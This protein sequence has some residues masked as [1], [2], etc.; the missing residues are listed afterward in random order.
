MIAHPRPAVGTWARQRMASLIPALAFTLG[1]G[2]VALL[3]V[4]KPRLSADAMDGL[5]RQVMGR[6]PVLAEMGGAHGNVEYNP[7]DPSVAHRPLALTLA[8]A[9][10]YFVAVL[11]LGAPIVAAV[12]GDDRWP[13]A[14][15]GLA[16]FL[17]GYL[18]VL[19]PVQLLYGVLPVRTASWVALAAVPAAAILLH[20][21]AITAA[22]VEPGQRAAHARRLGWAAVG[23]VLMVLVM[24]VHRLQVD[25]DY[26]TQD[27]IHWFLEAG[28]QQLGQLLGTHLAQWASQSDEWVFNA[29]LMFSSTNPGDIWLPFYLTQAIGIASVAALAYGLVHRHAR[30]RK[31]L[32]GVVVVSAMFTATVSIYPWVYV[33]LVIGGQPL[34]WL[35]HTGRL[36]GI[37]APWAALLLV[38]R[39]SRSVTALLALTTMGLAFT[40]AEVLPHV[41]IA[42][43][44]VL[45][46]RA[47]S[48]RRAGWLEGRGGALVHLL[49]VAALSLCALPFWAIQSFSDKDQAAWFL[50]AAMLLALAGA[51][52]L[53]VNSAPVVTQPS[54]S[55]RWLVV[56]PLVAL[57]G[58]LLSNNLIGGSE[59]GEAIR[60][61]IGSVLPGFRGELLQRPDIG[62]GMFAGLSFPNLSEGACSALIECRGI[63]D[64][65]A[66][67][68]VLSAI[69]WGTWAALG[70]LTADVVA[71]A[72]R[73][74]VLLL[75]AL[76]A[77]ALV[78]LFFVGGA[79]PEADAGLYQTAIFTRL[80]ELPLYGV[81]ILAG[82]TFVEARNRWT[83]AVGTAFLVVWTITPFVAFDR[84]QEFVRNAGWYLH[85]FG[86]T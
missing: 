78:I 11:A 2:V 48:G 4:P 16:G 9:L 43:V 12:R 46:W 60:D 14:L 27:S 36:I 58:L 37:V 33:R 34:Y 5:A 18:I 15:S 79:P 7:L 85:H 63:A 49:P 8:L 59:A 44:A 22:W 40:S 54:L 70:S 39:H 86:I 42:V 26:L 66:T 28:G 62:D 61:A 73:A 69:A 19:A 64:F 38:R 25:G 84:P 3:T 47:L 1:L 17:P 77:G 23:V 72:R 71:N 45:L 29:P 75:I 57:A 24:L 10:P 13:S 20:R 32:A 21:K 35:G 80:I 55:R 83:F 56:W 65:L 74:L 52:A 51:V 68:G 41:A 53:A 31:A 67:F 30:Q 6:V 76:L 50:V 81:L 82:I